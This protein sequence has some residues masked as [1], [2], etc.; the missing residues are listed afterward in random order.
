MP[1]LKQHSNNQGWLI[2]I[3]ESTSPPLWWRFFFWPKTMGRHNVPEHVRSDGM[4]CPICRKRQ[5]FSDRCTFCGCAFSCFVV[6]KADTF[7]RNKRHSNG[8]A[9][10]ATE[11]TGTIHDLLTPLSA[12][13]ISFSTAS[14]RVRMISFCVIFLFMVSLAVGIM[15]YRSF[16]QKDYTQKFVVALYG[17]NSGMNLA[18][19]VCDGKYKAWKEGVSIE[20]SESSAIDSQT[21]ADLEGVKAYVDETRG[22]MGTPPAEFDQSERMLQK[23]YDIYER[24]NY[25]IINSPESL[26]LLKTEIVAARIEFSR[27][28]GNLKANLPAPLEE[29]F[30]K[31]N[32]KYDLSFMLLKK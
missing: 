20:I 26:S 18:G 32:Q 17:I 12:S 31:A 23:L 16:L 7:P 19:M 25:R 6:M 27:E 2:G 15:Q 22:E 5:P 30:K 9:S 21:T 8:D 11:K 29:E 3:P 28:L 13:L 24:M 1:T 14:L 4:Y 10:P